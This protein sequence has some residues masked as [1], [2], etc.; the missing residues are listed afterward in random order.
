MVSN[1]TNIFLI[2]LSGMIVNN[3]LLIRFIGLCPFFGISNNIKASIG[4]GGAVIFVI[5]MATSISWLIYHFILLPSNLVYLRTASFILTIATFVQLV[6][7]VIRKISPTLY[8]A[9]GIYLPLITTNCA[10]LATAFF[11]IDYQLNFIK[12]VVYAISIGAGFFFSITTFAAIRERIEVAPLPAS[13]KG[14][15]I[16]FI[17]ASLMSL[18]F[19]GFKGL[20]GL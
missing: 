20:F 15:P 13:F 11:C 19:L 1:E 2:F 7:I 12:S 14:Y 17:V 4:M 9:L 3:I 8:R 16:A 6:E 18:A 5:V 10:I